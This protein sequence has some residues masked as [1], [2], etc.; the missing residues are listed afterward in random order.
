MRQE[1][2]HAECACSFAR[3]GNIRAAEIALENARTHNERRSLV[4]YASR[5]VAHCKKGN[6]P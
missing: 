6:A 3:V 4:E 5:V 2:T 1:M